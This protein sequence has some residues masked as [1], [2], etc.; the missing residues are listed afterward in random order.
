MYFQ[1]SISRR[2][3]S[4]GFTLIELLIVT[5][6][7][8]LISTI[9]IPAVF[10]A[11]QKKDPLTQGV[12]DLMEACAQARAAA[13]IRC[14]PM[15]VKFHPYEYSFNVEK[16]PADIRDAMN[17][18]SQS[19]PRGSES[20][21]GS[22][23]GGSGG[24]EEKSSAQ[25]LKDSPYKG[26]SYTLNQELVIEMLDVNMNEHKDD[27]VVISRF[28]PNGTA[29]LLTVVLSDGGDFRRV[30]V[31]MVTGLANFD[32]LNELATPKN[33]MRRRRGNIEFGS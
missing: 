10:R 18:N 33:P 16:M 27:D 32:N 31:D 6:M 3:S 24:G 20:V 29:D 12:S 26:T 19:V 13:I 8:A 25:L 23:G 21:E 14:T 17:W 4:S 7:I 15:V 2:R 1:Q 22:L 11:F 5:A 28:F 30:R 9:G